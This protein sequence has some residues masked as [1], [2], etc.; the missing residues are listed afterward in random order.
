MLP[1]QQP[2]HKPAVINED[3]AMET[4][5]THGHERE[6]QV[7]LLLLSCLPSVLEEL[8]HTLKLLFLNS[9]ML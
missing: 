6:E 5:H 9:L 8:M 2:P 4:T 3:T 7:T 1:S